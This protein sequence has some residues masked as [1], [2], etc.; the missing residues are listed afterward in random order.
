MKKIILSIILSVVISFTASIFLKKNYKDSW[1]MTLKYEHISRKLNVNYEMAMQ[2]TNNNI[3]GKF[4]ERYIDLLDSKISLPGNS[5]P[6]SK[7][8][9][10]SN[11]PNILLSINN[12]AVKIS[13]RHKNKELLLD[14]EKF[15]DIEMN[16]FGKN[17]KKL[18][19]EMVKYKTSYQNSNTET[20]T[21]NENEE[22]INKNM[23]INEGKIYN[24]LLQEIITKQSDKNLGYDDLK[25]LA[26]SLTI[27]NILIDRN[28]Y[29]YPIS[30]KKIDS[31]VII[32]K[33]FRRLYQDK[34]NQKTLYISIFIISLSILIFFF[35]FNN[36]RSKKNKIKKLLKSLIN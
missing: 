14:C 13:M 4:F 18:I 32:E 11:V 36:I 19:K 1:E 9:Y 34:T 31:L 35:Y 17:S 15:I 22:S 10:Q 7:T 26:T 2:I 29:T 33:S 20:E 21:E 25:N 16:D 5:N 8:R 27:L 23:K 3:G 28:Q 6:C 24:L 12:D 30:E